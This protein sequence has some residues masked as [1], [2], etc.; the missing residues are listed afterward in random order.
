MSRE[1][2]GRSSKKFPLT[3]LGLQIKAHWLKHRP[4]MCA[5]LQRTGDFDEAV[6]HG[7]G[8]DQGPAGRP[9]EKPERAA[10]RS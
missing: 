9:A 7:L 1:R 5:D 4:N 10:G 6:L 3:R 8:A 2:P